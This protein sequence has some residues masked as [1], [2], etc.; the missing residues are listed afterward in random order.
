MQ[1]NVLGNLDGKTRLL[2]K[3]VTE[4]KYDELPHEV[5]ERAKTCVLDAL[6]S[7]FLG[8]ILPWGKIIR[9]YVTSIAGKP[10][11]RVIG[12]RVNVDAGNAALANGTM[13]HGFEV[14]DVLICA[15]HHPGAVIVPAALATAERE[16]S[17]GKEFIA[18]VVAGYEVMNRVGKAVGTES[19][20]M[21]G[22]FPTSTN[23]PFGAAA[24]AGKLLHLTA[25]QMTDALGIAGSQS[26]GLFEGIKEGMMTKRFGAG[27]AAHSGV[28]AADL[29]KLGFT[30]S[31]TVLEGEWGY[32]K[33]FSDN[34]DPSRLTEKLGDCYNILETTFKPY[35]C[36]KALHA[37]IDGM[38]ELNGRY[39]FDPDQVTEVVVGGYEKLVRMH[40]IYEPAT[41][42][43][44][45]FSIPYV[46]SVAL[47]KGSP[48][49]EAFE[50]KS[51]RDK[52][53]LG[54]ARRVKLTIDPE[55]T[56]YFPAH[57]PSKVTVRLK[58]GTGC[59]TT[60][61]CSKGTP[62][63]PMSDRELEA[64]FRGFAS[65]VIPERSAGQAVELIRNLD[66]LGSVKEL[67]AVLG[68]KV[69]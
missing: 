17:T 28:M 10:E 27:R 26:G 25:G 5:I 45:Q 61:I 30:G 14:D 29:A 69:A 2:A 3:F 11:S 63:N 58:N 6:G 8:S 49:V 41:S 54:F 36:C 51:I 4:L 38:L 62:D 9:A 33:A 18:A 57:E 52:E 34:A 23:G 53:V 39:H 56:P 21:R 50:E 22:F 31:R 55:V 13:A 43:A 20:V 46:V 1:S 32:L 37:A 16:D 48:G 24:A 40:D 19:H 15:L 12:G 68:K 66:A 42:M 67:S 44:A 47:L 59:S 60:V 65:Q 7:T 35:P 64:K